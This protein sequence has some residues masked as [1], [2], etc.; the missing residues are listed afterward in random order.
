MT[1]GGTADIV[2]GAPVPDWLREQMEA[3][4]AGTAELSMST[5]KELYGPDAGYDAP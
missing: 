5:V 4:E 1:R 3:L 2:R